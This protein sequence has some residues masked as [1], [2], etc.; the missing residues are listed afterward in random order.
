M[1]FILMVWYVSVIV[2]GAVMVFALM[3]LI[4][5]RLEKGML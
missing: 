2:S 1:D 3:F 5:A 4:P